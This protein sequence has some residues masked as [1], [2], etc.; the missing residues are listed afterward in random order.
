MGIGIP[1]ALYEVANLLRNPWHVALYKAQLAGFVLATIIRRLTSGEP[2]ILIGHSLGARVIAFALEALGK[3][4]SGKVGEAHL[5]GGAIGSKPSDWWNG[6]SGALAEQ[7]R[8]RKTD[9]F[10]EG[11]KAMAERR[12]PQFTGK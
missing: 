11:V 8:L 2:V 4:G 12:V 7:G 3:D 6:C 1:F 5:L 9:D 10:K